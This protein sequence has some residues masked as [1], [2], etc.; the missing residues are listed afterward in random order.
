MGFGVECE[1]TF[2]ISM[3]DTLH[4]FLRVKW[5]MLWIEAEI[6]HSRGAYG[7]HCIDP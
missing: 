5:R 6:L 7:Y 1:V 3:D 4:C 2:V